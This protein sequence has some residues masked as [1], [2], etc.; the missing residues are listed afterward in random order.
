MGNYAFARGERGQNWIIAPSP[1]GGSGRTLKK[2]AFAH[3]AHEEESN[4]VFRVK[5]SG[6]LMALRAGRAGNG[7]DILRFHCA[8]GAEEIR[9]FT[10]LIGVDSSGTPL[11]FSAKRMFSI[12]GFVLDVCSF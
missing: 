7:K 4:S 9:Y 1:R 10:V 3:G 11:F 8:E 6:L 12:L 2:H 5:I